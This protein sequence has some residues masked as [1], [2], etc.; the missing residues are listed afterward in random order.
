MGLNTITMKDFLT[1]AAVLVAVWGAGYL[2]VVFLTW[3]ALGL[4]NSFTSSNVD[5]NVWIMGLLAWIIVGV[6][7]F[8]GR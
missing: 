4:Y 6:F 7:S 3:L 2:F 5:L 1:F 8:G